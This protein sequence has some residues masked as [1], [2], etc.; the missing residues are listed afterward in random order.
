MNLDGTQVDINRIPYRD[1]LI[2]EEKITSRQG[3]LS[4][5]KIILAYKSDCEEFLAKITVR[6]CDITHDT[7]LE[8]FKSNGDFLWKTAKKDT[9]VV[10]CLF[11]AKEKLFHILF[12]EELPDEHT[13]L[14]TYNLK[15]EEIFRENYADSIYS[16]TGKN[17][18]LLYYI[19]ADKK[20]KTWGIG[21][22]NFISNSSWR[23][24]IS[25]G[26][27]RLCSISR[28]GGK[29][30]FWANSTLYSWTANRK[31][32]WKKKSSKPGW[33]ALS[34]NGDL[35][36][37][38]LKGGIVHCYDNLT[39]N[40]IWKKR[41]ITGNKYKSRTAGITFIRNTDI[42]VLSAASWP[43]KLLLMFVDGKGTRLDSVI[44]EYTQYPSVI[45]FVKK[46]QSNYVTVLCKGLPEK[47]IKVKF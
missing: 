24:D 47:T 13:Y 3:Y 14:V 30:V 17:T 46:K 22:K 36:I 42:A 38:L 10:T 27:G 6:S 29:L 34:H 15:G 2:V 39:G 18:N 8:I 44:I 33:I 26:F 43:N 28:D 19:F 20:K 41:E 35:M 23:Q 12:Q 32:L 5:T 25:S 4:C 7:V 45:M 11:A 31:E 37:R 16:Y 1:I 40:L 9:F 21:C